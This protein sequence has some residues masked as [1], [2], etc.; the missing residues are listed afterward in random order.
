[1]SLLTGSPTLEKLQAL[2]AAYADDPK[3]V[4]FSNEFPLTNFPGIFPSGYQRG[5]VQKYGGTSVVSARQDVAIVD[6]AVAT[7]AKIP[8]DGFL[9]VV[10]SGQGK[11]DDTR[12]KATEHMYDMI[13]GIKPREAWELVKGNYFKKLNDHG[14]KFPHILL[15]DEI[16]SVEDRFQD[17]QIPE[18]A[19]G[20]ILRFPEMAQARIIYE[21]GTQR[22][23]GMSWKLL[24]FPTGLIGKSKSGEVTDQPIDF[25]SSYR[26]MRQ[27]N[28]EDALAGKI[29]IVPGFTGGAH[30][31]NIVKTVTF[32]RG[33]SDAMATTWGAAL[34]VDEVMI[35]SDT[36]GMYPMDPRLV[37]GLET[38]KEI[39]NSECAVFTDLGA[40]VMQH[41]ALHPVTEHNIPTYIRNSAHP[42][43]HGTK[44]WNCEPST[45]HYG[46]RAVGIANVDDQVRIALVG[47]G[48]E[49]VDLDQKIFLREN[50]DRVGVVSEDFADE[51]SIT[52]SVLISSE[53]KKLALETIADSF[54][55]R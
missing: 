43:D 42:N 23:P 15:Y 5:V 36:N 4:D 7:R 27:L 1:M 55:F 32:E 28:R 37:P 13:K 51:D 38:L 40:A 18:N 47:E 9:V 33:S 44:I 21:L 6:Y 19:Y 12:R 11:I 52:C 14:V 29:L 54:E 24:D 22:Y 46:V 20:N 45:E 41:V 48:M 49:L 25:E 10:V 17:G 39:S 2:I 31:D 8:Q 35:F 53:Q 30:I 34:G 16:A 3:G 26:I 50:L